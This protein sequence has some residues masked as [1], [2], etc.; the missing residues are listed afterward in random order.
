MNVF[1]LMA[2]LAE[3]VHD[4]HGQDEVFIQADHIAY[5]DVVKVAENPFPRV[6]LTGR[7]TFADSWVEIS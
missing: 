1:E 4:N 7:P 2:R 3:L 6:V 5:V